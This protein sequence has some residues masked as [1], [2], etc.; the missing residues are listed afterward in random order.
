MQG[1]AQLSDQAFWDTANC[2]PVPAYSNPATLQYDSASHKMAS[3]DFWRPIGKQE[4]A[5][6]RL[7]ILV[8]GYK[9][10]SYNHT[11]SP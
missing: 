3:Y 9:I 2:N 8:N 6:W 5:C 4:Q 7:L 10:L 11:G 1:E